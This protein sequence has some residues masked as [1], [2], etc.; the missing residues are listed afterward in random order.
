MLQPMSSPCPKGA[1]RRQP[2][3]VPWAIVALVLALAP[4]GGVATPLGEVGLAQ[5]GRERWTR[6]VGLAGNWVRDITRGP[7]GFLWV[8]ASGGLSRFDGRSFV[9]YA[10]VN[11]RELPSSS[12]A[13]LAVGSQGRLWVGLEH[14]G[15]RVLERERLRE[16]PALAALPPVSVRTLLEDA[17]GRLWIGT[18]AGLWRLDAAGL[19]RVAPEGADGAAEIRRLVSAP[20]GELWAR[21]SGDGLWR[22]D[23]GTASSELDAPGCVGLDLARFGDGRWVTSCET[24]I[25]TRLPDGGAWRELS[26]SENAQR[27]YATRDGALWFQ[28]PQGLARW[29]PRG[30]ERLE[31]ELGLGDVRIR[32]F[33]ED[34]EGDLWVGTFSAGLS[35]LRRGAVAAVGTPEGLDATGTTGVAATAAGG[36]W[37]GT[38]DQG[39][40]LWNPARGVERRVTRADGLGSDRVWSVAEDPQRPG[41]VWFGTSEGLFEL[42]GRAI[43][44]LPL[45]P[46]HERD[47][48]GLILPD[49]LLPDVLWA[50][51]TAGAIHELRAGRFRV[52]H[53]ASSGLRGGRVRSLG[54]ERSG[55]LLAG[56]EDGL[57]RF[58]GSRWESVPLGGLS[59]RIVRA[60]AE[61]ADGAL[62]IASESSGLLRWV[63][64]K[65][66]R[67]GAREGLPFD[68]IYSLEFDRTGGLWLSG[69]DGLVRLRV[70][71]FDRWAAGEIDSVPFEMLSA[72]DGLR[73][74]ECNGWGRPASAS[75]SDGTLVYPTL[76]GIARVDPAALAGSEL[77]AGDLYVDRA[78]S[79]DRELDLTRPLELTSQERQLRL[80]FGAREFLRPESVV[81]R[82]RLEGAS[83][84]WLTASRRTEAVYS[85]L[86]PG[87][88]RFRI[89]ARL[90]GQDWVEAATSIPIV[91][92]PRLFETLGF[93]VGVLALALALVLSAFL[94][95][96]N[97]ERAHAAAIE[98]ERAFLREVI[99]TSPNPIFAKGR[100]LAYTLANRAA[101]A[102]Y[103][104]A[105]GDLVGRADAEIVPERAGLDEAV[106]ADREVL[107]SGEE[108]MLPE[109]RTV[110]AAGQ[111]RWFRVAKRPLRGSSGRV[112]QVIGTSVDVTDFK[113]SEER[114]R[115]REVELRASR[116]E[117]RRLARQLLRAQEEER[118]RLAREIHDDLTQRLAGLAMLTGSLSRTAERAGAGELRASLEQ[119]RHELERLASD[120]QG[121]ARDLHPA[122]LEN[123]GLLEALR[124]ECSSF[125]ERAGLAIR[126]ESRDVPEE[127]PPEVS[128]AF[129]RIAQ[130]ALRNVAAH[131]ETAGARVCLE[132]RGGSLVLSVEDGGVGIPPAVL[133]GAGGGIG[134]ASMAER[135][136][137]IDA[138]FGIESEPGAGT[139]VEVRARLAPERGFP[140]G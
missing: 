70:R 109:I 69:D 67:L 74:Q 87:R 85:Y 91:V 27:I 124:A 22:I 42:E 113:V 140:A 30:A 115:A 121:I 122:M 1:A 32:A 131:A 89:Q 97:V 119:I 103:G 61:G 55:T 79:G 101:A 128:L 36:V 92:A 118:R 59:P 99:D 72:R 31:P 127:L 116:E 33:F 23:G 57:F 35:R 39:A 21:T 24:G 9:N 18:S 112:E 60:W 117:L 94:W 105:P 78:W 14:G 40:Y 4:A 28:S 29:T 120:T 50:C 37:L 98:R 7:D 129:Y 63:G 8:A 114:L 110:D 139:R 104:L 52:L 38:H 3:A 68:N 66:S 44:R 16:E 47:E 77:A 75:L 84:G 20:S 93:R 80:R 19:E 45:A 26:P 11:E 43:R 132:A 82:Y 76:R 90:P 48:I 136:K 13:A 125:G 54:R 46:G 135:A 106:A 51:D 81:F 83:P 111:M 123:L 49:P 107:E 137:L 134:L 12:V 65:L 102:F 73:E 126:F 58:D 15:V 88:Y 108:R 6:D 10:A 41:H 138:E 100:D 62:W 53:D 64:G 17:H 96:T 25:W 86:E 56:A 130:E 95:R 133:A 5:L 2:A 71:D 34:G